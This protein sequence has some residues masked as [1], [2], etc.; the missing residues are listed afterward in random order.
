[1][2]DNGENFLFSLLKGKQ[3]MMLMSLPSPFAIRSAGIWKER[4]VFY[5]IL[6]SDSKQSNSL[7]DVDLKFEM[8]SMKK[9]QRYFAIIRPQD[10]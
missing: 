7:K 1:M 8:E 6:S 4:L 3:V 10:K 9:S 5:N 2:F